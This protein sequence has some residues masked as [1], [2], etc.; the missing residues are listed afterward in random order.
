M[1]VCILLIDCLRPDRLSCYGYTKKTSPSIDTV[2]EEGTRFMNAYAQSNWTYPSIYSLITG[3]YPSVLDITWVDQ[4]INSSFMILPELLARNN[5]TTGLFSNFKILLNEKSLCSHFQEVREV[6][7]DDSLCRTFKEW[8]CTS[9]DSFLLLHNGQYVHEPF[10]ADESNVLPFLPHKSR[11][12]DRKDAS[13][14]LRAL[15]SEETTSNSIRKTIG[16]LNRH[17]VSL[18]SQEKEYL[19]ACYNG[20]IH[21]VDRYVGELYSL[22]RNQDDDYL[23]IITADHGQS[24]FEHGV[25]GHGISLFNQEIRVPLIV[26]MKNGTPSKCIETVQHTDVVP[27]ILDLLNIKNTATLDGTSFVPA[28]RGD[29]LENR[30]AFS[31]GFPRVALMRDG[32]KLITS[33]SRFWDNREITKRFKKSKTRSLRKSI[34][35]TFLRYWPPQ[36][37]DIHKDA[38]ETKN[39]VLKK[40]GIYKYMHAEMEKIMGA[41]L[42]DSLPPED[43]EINEQ[44]K[45][46]LESLGYL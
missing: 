29:K 41:I 44:T 18:S 8:L 35:N 9:G 21:Q 34:L 6:S 22:I 12:R 38:G 37:F 33:Y 25:F 11:F 5:F 45:K 23:F 30:V 43:A 27:S 46:Q 24:L 19:L 42:K 32:Y 4:K 20:G 26:A 16:N 1:K 13:D 17:I 15:V 3:R 31:E 10:C 36:L 39:L 2:A 14:T 28:L 7:L 40:R